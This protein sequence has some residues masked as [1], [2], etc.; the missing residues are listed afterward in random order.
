NDGVSWSLRYP[1]A[2]FSVYS[3]KSVVNC[4]PKLR[5]LTTLFFSRLCFPITGYHPIAE[6]FFGQFNSIGINKKFLLARVLRNELQA[7]MKFLKPF[8]K[9]IR[10]RLILIE[11]LFAQQFSRAFCETDPHA[12]VFLKPPGKFVY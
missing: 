11:S 3:V 9:K 4:F 1:E 6:D 10:D 8:R 5:T 12:V 2:D 7:K